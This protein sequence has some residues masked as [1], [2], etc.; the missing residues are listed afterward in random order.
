[1]RYIKVLTDFYLD[2]L[3][4]RFKICRDRGWVGDA[5]EALFDQMLDLIEE[6]GVDPENS[7]PSYEDWDDVRDN[8]LLSNDEYACMQ[9]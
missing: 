3:K 6:V 9:F 1:M 7:D 2:L 5:A 8:A 4:D